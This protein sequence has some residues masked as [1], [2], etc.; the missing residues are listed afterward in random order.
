MKAQ[1]KDFVQSCATC[2]QAKTDRSKYPGLL[3]PLPTPDAAWQMVTMDFV[4][5][6]PLSGSA[7]SI[8]VVVDKFTRYAHFIPLQHPFTAAKVASAYLNNVFKLHSLPKVMVS[9]RD[10]VFTSRFWRELFTQIGSELR[11]SSSYHP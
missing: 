10:P 1:T 5:G 9:D 2:Q 8:V 11:M 7:N 3:E 4:E 6:L